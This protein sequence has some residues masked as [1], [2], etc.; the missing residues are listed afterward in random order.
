MQTHAVAVIGAQVER[1]LQGRISTLFGK[2]NCPPADS[3]EAFAGVSAAVRATCELAPVAV[4]LTQDGV[5]AFANT[6]LARLFGL[7]SSEHLQGRKLASLLGK[8]SVQA[9]KEHVA[10]AFAFGGRASTTH[11]FADEAPSL[12]PGLQ[13]HFSLVTAALPQEAAG[14]LHHVLTD[15]TTTAQAQLALER[16]RCELRQLSASQV[17]AREAE[18]RHIAREM[19]DELGQR[20]T[21][22]K[23]ELASMGRLSAK[24][25][26]ERVQA[27]LEMVDD[28][29]AS[30]RRIASDL[31]P[32]ML[33]DLG[34]NA[35]IEW[36]VRESAK[37]SGLCI[38]PCLGETMLPAHQ[39]ATVGI[40]IYRI[41][42][43]ALTNVARHAQATQVQ[44]ELKQVDGHLHLRVG[45]NGKGFCNPPK[46]PNHSHGL[47]GIRER[48]F[49]L[50]G[51]FEIANGPQ[52]GAQLTV[53]IPLDAA[54]S[55][56]WDTAVPQPQSVRVPLGQRELAAAQGGQAIIQ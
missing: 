11:V 45:D 9:L 56:T 44:I 18:R 16:S 40:A 37:R 36:L 42:Q 25:K 26:N 7:S 15:I 10:L 49:S 48:V 43:E 27:M 2:G 17:E 14:L 53:R 47:I 55:V 30:V 35:A 38:T 39:E 1:R 4:C 19:H 34:L 32:L 12:G 24:S 46:R 29:V 22:L 21:A 5:I 23:M 54:N 52:G 6:A 31:R 33:D 28:T 3:S 13:R 50:G 41:T 8:Q 51:Q 20:L